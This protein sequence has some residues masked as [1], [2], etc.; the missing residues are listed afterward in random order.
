MDSRKKPKTIMIRPEIWEK[1]SRISINTGLSR[2][3]LIEIS[4]KTLFEDESLK[5]EGISL[6]QDI[7][8][9]T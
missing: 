6:K 1:L 5:D 3:A 4:L 8:K 7:A 9:Y 2:S